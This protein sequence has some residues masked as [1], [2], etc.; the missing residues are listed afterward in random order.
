LVEIH[1]VVPWEEF[2][3]L[4]EQVWCKPES[5]RKSK[6]ARKLLDAVLMFKAF[7]LSAF[8]NLFGRSSPISDQGPLIFY[9]LPDR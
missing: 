8:Y 2:P 9:A 4:L 1:D 7:V 6:A 5:E 3:P